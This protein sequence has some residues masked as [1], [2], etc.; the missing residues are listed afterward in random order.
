MAILVR[1][2]LFLIRRSKTGN[3]TDNDIASLPLCISNFLMFLDMTLA[4]AALVWAD[5]GRPCAV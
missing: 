2:K 1:P 5:F 4:V 3:E